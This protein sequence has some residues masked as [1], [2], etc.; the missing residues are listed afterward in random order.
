MERIYQE[1]IQG[2]HKR[3]RELCVD[4]FSNTWMASTYY[5]GLKIHKWIVLFL[6][7]VVEYAEKDFSEINAT[8]MKNYRKIY[9]R[10]DTYKVV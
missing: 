4:L 8:K 6:Q 9:N 10:T 7:N 2:A 5:F 1:M 3:L